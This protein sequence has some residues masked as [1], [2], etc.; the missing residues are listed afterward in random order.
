MLVL[1]AVEGRAS[2]LF[3]ALE[4]HLR[5]AIDEGIL[6]TNQAQVRQL[7]KMVPSQRAE[8]RRAYVI[9]AGDIEHAQLNGN[10][11]YRRDGARISFGVTMLETPEGLNLDSYR[12]SIRFRH[13]A[14]PPFIRFDL[15]TPRPQDPLTAPRCHIHPGSED[16]VIPTL[17]MA[18]IEI[19]DR[20]LYGMPHP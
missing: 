16:V 11:F 13:G 9:G 19:L 15:N 6:V 17:A 7:L 10:F 4:T 12:F 18:P 14:I 2:S 5:N 1:P 8:G 20:F 3:S